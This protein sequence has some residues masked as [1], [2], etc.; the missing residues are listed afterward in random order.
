MKIFLDAIDFNLWDYNIDGPF[1]P[2]RFTNNE[3]LNKPSNLW[4]HKK[5]KKLKQSLKVKYLM[6]SPLSAREYNYVSNCSNSKEVGDTLEMIYEGS[7][8]IKKKMM[9]ILY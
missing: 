8:K 4:T 2:T 3:V 1:V 9:N 5:R 6:I 7:T